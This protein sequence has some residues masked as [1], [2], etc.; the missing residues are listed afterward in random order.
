MGV[1]DSL[2]NAVQGFRDDWHYHPGQSALSL[3]AGT[4]APGA[5]QAAQFGF[6]KYND[7]HGTSP[8]QLRAQEFTDAH[9]DDN[10]AFSDQL[11]N[12][13]NPGGPTTQQM[14]AH[15][16]SGY[17]MA[18]DYSQQGSSGQLAFL[19]DAP[20]NQPTGS[21]F[22][23]A[24]YAPGAQYSQQYNQGPGQT[25]GGNFNM[26]QLIGQPGMDNSSGYNMSQQYSAPASADLLDFLGGAGSMPTG[27]PHNH[28]EIDQ[29]K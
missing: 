6:H 22:Q 26:S 5:G 27:D 15:L 24:Q 14:D 13:M 29:P 9:G 7:V 1:L 8:N 2:G 19:G 10:Q 4:F 18:H 17:N 20:Q 25:F 3:L 28:R 12:A 23:G 11:T 16:L 21:A